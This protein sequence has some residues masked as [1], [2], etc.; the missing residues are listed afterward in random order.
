MIRERIAAAYPG[1]RKVGLS[2]WLIEDRTIKRV[3]VGSVESSIVG[4]LLERFD[5]ET[6]IVEAHRPIKIAARPFRAAA[7]D[8]L[9]AHPSWST[10]PMRE[11]IGD[12]GILGQNAWRMGFNQLVRRGTYR[13]ADI[14]IAPITPEWVEAFAP[15]RS[16]RE[17]RP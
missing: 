15:P 8:M 9:Y 17:R 12:L 4:A 14:D 10:I 1:T 7:R 5:P 2:L 13:F 6:L 3:A 16:P 11:I